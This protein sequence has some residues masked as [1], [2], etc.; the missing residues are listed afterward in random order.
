MIPKLIHYCWFGR[1]QKPESVLA[2]I[3]NWKEMLPDF[4]IIEWNE[5]NFDVLSICYSAQA[6][7]EKKY[8][9]VSDVARLQA[10]YQFGGVYLDTDVDVR[11]DLTPLLENGITLGFE[12]FNFIATSTLI[13]PAGSKLIGDFLAMYLDRTFYGEDGTLDQTT[14]V[15]KLTDILVRAGLLRDGSA[16]QL[17]YQG[18][19]IRILP[20]VLLSP[21]DY[22]N[23]I[24]NSDASTYTIHHF[25]QSW[26]TGQSRLNSRLKNA[27]RAVV[28]GN[29]IKLLRRYAGMLRR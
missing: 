12:E 16:Q 3:R 6:Y 22:P 17:A 2:Y 20:Q 5:D 21:L 10:L 9:F 24:D 27:L 13:A 7:A 14:N 29:G 19:N 1:N 15:V 8:A 18:E 23:G 26:V 28:G 4:E 25:G 11:K